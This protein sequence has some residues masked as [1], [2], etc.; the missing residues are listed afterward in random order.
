[1]HHFPAA[2]K[3]APAVPGP[4]LPSLSR[5]F[6]KDTGNGGVA[7]LDAIVGNQ[8]PPVRGPCGD[9][10]TEEDL[11]ALPMSPRSPEMKRSPFSLL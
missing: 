1:M 8:F 9:D 4:L 10:N 5:P 7:S 2:A 11:F 3:T 6:P